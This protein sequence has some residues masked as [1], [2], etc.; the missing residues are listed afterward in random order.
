MDK[1]KGKYRTTTTRATFWDY[2]ANAAYFVTICTNNREH[3][4]GEVVNGEMQ[5]S[6]IGR[7]ADEC[8]RAIPEHFPFVQL[9]SHIIM[10]NHVHGIIIIDKPE[11]SQISVQPQDLA[12]QPTNLPPPNPPENAGKNK[13]GPQSRNLASIVRGFKIGV[14][15]GARLI[16]PLFKWQP[17][18]HDHIIRDDRAYQNI[19][20]YIENNPQ[21]WQDDT[22]NGQKE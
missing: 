22:F 2:G 13:F 3:S 11:N 10:P 19:S 14:T 9:D 5:L 16:D 4:F 21:K 1:Y 12:A 18:Y 20:N 15:K 17:L 7:V 8:W 6:E